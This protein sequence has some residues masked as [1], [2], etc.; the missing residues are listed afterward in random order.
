M[1]PLEHVAKPDVCVTE[2]EK[3]IQHWQHPEEHGNFRG[4][5][6]LRKMMPNEYI[7]G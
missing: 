7:T 5:R 3:N 4:W 2:T 6:Q 1:S